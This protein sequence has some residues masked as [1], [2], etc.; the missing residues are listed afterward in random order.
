MT[1]DR[2]PVERMKRRFNAKEV[3]ERLGVSVRT[4]SRHIKEGKLPA[5]RTGKDYIITRNDLAVYL[6]GIERVN[7]LFAEDDD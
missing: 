6:G 7:E 2:P 1:T 3:A 4:I 5:V